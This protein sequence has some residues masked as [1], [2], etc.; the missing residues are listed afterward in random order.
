MSLQDWAGRDLGSRTVGWEPRDAIL[1][2]LAV[3]AP[4]DRLDLVWERQLRVLPT[5]G[6]TLAQWAPDVLSGNGAVD[7]ANSLHGAQSFTSL[8]AM[9][10][11]G[12][13][14]LWARVGEVW[15]KGAA[16]IVEVI[17]ECEYF[18]TTWSLF[19]PGAGGFGGARG[20]GRAPAPA[21]PPSARLTL[22]TAANQAVL[23]RLLGDQHAIH[24]QPEAARHAGLDRPL[25]HG[26]CTLAAATLSIAERYGAHP[27][28]L[29]RLEARF[30]S[31]VYPGDLVDLEVW[32]VNEQHTFAGRTG[33]SVAL[34]E[35]LVTFR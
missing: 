17:V 13:V 18:T 28:D 11:Q 23:Y 21:T 26:L 29:H 24:V 1:Y 34:T 16:A 9:P 33:D 27:A 19:Q 31:P 2:A 3:G 5:F 6:L 15:D 14:E 35:G 32:D 30:A 8:T 12:E 10:A 4:P 20:P 25:L 22:P 7:P